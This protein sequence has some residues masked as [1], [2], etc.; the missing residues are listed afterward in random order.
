[1]AWLGGCVHPAAYRYSLPYLELPLTDDTLR[2]DLRALASKLETLTSEL[3]ASYTELLK[4]TTKT[5]EEIRWHDVMLSR[6]TRDINE[7]EE[8]IKA[9]K[10]QLN[11]FEQRGT[12][13]GEQLDESVN[14]LRSRVDAK[15]ANIFNRNT[16]YA[17]AGLSTLITL[18]IAIFTYLL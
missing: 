1:M 7:L 14:D 16:A 9:V 8:D 6:I 5:T 18:A 4:S 10:S 3:R 2:E 11:A 17:V 12:K 15:Q 13:W